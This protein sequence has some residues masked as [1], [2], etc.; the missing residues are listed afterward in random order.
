MKC[1][2]AHQFE[3]PPNVQWLKAASMG[4]QFVA[5]GR[6]MDEN[7]PQIIAARSGWS[8]P[9]QV[10]RWNLD[11]PNLPFFLVPVLKSEQCW[12]YQPEQPLLPDQIL[13]KTT[14]LYS[15]PLRVGGGG[16][17]PA[18]TIRVVVDDE[19][20]AW[21]LQRRR[22]GKRT[23]LFPTA[24]GVTAPELEYREVQNYPEHIRFYR[25]DLDGFCSEPEAFQE[26]A[27]PIPSLHNPVT[28]C[29]LSDSAALG[30][31]QFLTFFANR[32]VVGSLDLRDTILDLCR[33][34]DSDKKWLWIQ[35]PEGRFSLW[36]GGNRYLT[37]HTGFR[38][39][40]SCPLVPPF[41]IVWGAEGVQILALQ[42]HG[43]VH[44]GKHHWG[45]DP[46]IAALSTNEPNHFAT[47]SATGSVGIWRLSEL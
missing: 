29:G 46:P 34:E 2:L 42:H 13:S 11:S 5:I 37:H 23:T 10:I 30:M 6:S 39:P 7:K 41:M 40:V 8:G 16:W 36:T 22:R 35:H 27:I 38:M 14:T 24:D 12:V 3:L 25:C 21:V 31:G 32:S 20:S 15:T 18:G 43:I 33:V 44:L 1:K 9:G 4:T 19:G 47:L 45:K 26:A 28:L 17:L